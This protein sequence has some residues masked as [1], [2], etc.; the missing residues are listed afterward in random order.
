M[1][2]SKVIEKF[3]KMLDAD[4][5]AITEIIN[6]FKSNFKNPTH[7]LSLNAFDKVICVTPSPDDLNYK[8]SEL[9]QKGGVYIFVMKDDCD[10][11]QNFNVSGK[12]RAKLRDPSNKKTFDRGDILYIGK[13]QQ[14][15]QRMC[16]HIDDSETNKVG[17]LKLKCAERR[18]LI[19]KFTILAFC[20]K[21]NYNSDYYSMIATKVEKNLR[22]KLK[23]LVGQ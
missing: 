22:L 17:S 3:S 13:C 11:N 9:S 23:P 6:Q 5:D 15:D 4:C 1:N 2:F 19:G 21:E 12:Y 18:N 16:S 20:L 14:L 10:I 7:A 8:F